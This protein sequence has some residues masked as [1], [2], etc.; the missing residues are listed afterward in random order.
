MGS[1]S[2]KTIHTKLHAP[3]KLVRNKYRNDALYNVGK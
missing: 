2:M 1:F 3:Y